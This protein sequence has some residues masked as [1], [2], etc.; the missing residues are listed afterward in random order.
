M[1]VSD[2]DRPWL[3]TPFLIQGFEITCEEDIQEVSNVCKYVY[4]DKKKSGLY[5][6]ALDE[7]IPEKHFVPSLAFKLSND[8]PAI[9]FRKYKTPNNLESFTKEKI[10]EVRHVYQKTRNTIH[11]TLERL[12]LGHEIDIFESKQAV[13]DC[14]DSIFDNKDSLLWYTLIKKR[15]AYTSEHSLNVTILS[16]AF[17][18]YL[19]HT[20]EE[21]QKIG[22]CGLL[23]DVGK[24]KIPLEILTKEGRFTKEDFDI[25]KLHPGYGYEY[26]IE[27]GNVDHE[28]AHAAYS[29]HERM[30]G[31]GYPQGLMGTQISYYAKLIAITDTFDAITNDRCYQQGRT[32][33][34]A[35]KILYEL[36]GTHY[37]EVLVKSFIQ[38]LGIYPPAS[39]VEMSNGEVGIVLTLNPE[40]K[41]KPRIILILDQDKK[42]QPQ[43]IVDLYQ[44][45]TDL[46][47]NSYYIKTSHPNNS[48]GISLV[49]F[50]L[51]ELTNI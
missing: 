18:R 27:Q 28:V 44:D 49:D 8:E 21:V 16:I 10:N 11:Q 40:W 12:K 22:L 33:M 29:H 32:T 31:S 39:I 2:L 6:Y 9:K 47:G 25:M 23:H 24:I 48:F 15:D 19:G 34:K 13:E 50:K 41:T 20:K 3:G 42:P 46:K 37:D 45:N 7:F 38:W 35:Q 4:I 1:F 14:V 5:D 36:A 30:N 26:L 51:D 17:A 43:R